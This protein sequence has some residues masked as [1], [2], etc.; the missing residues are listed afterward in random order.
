MVRWSSDEMKMDDGAV[1]EWSNDIQGDKKFSV[2]LM[3]TV[4]KRAKIF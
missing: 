3:I 2:H 4:Q 1:E